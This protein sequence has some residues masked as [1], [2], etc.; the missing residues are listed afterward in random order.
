[1]GVDSDFLPFIG[2]VTGK[3]VALEG[4][5]G[6]LNTTGVAAAEEAVDVSDEFRV[7]E[8]GLGDLLAAGG[9]VP[10]PP[11]STAPSR[12]VCACP[13]RRGATFR[14]ALRRRFCGGRARRGRDDRREDGD[15]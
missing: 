8:D 5:T 2:S 15:G 1:L 14:G 12:S 6:L 10:G 7:R 13:P 11:V 3:S 4:V 9:R